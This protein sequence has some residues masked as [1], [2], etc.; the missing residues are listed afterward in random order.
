MNKILFVCHGT[1]EGSRELAVLVGQNGT[2]CGIGNSGDYGFT[3][4]E[5]S[6]LKRLIFIL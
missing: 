6:K 5:G 1:T 4:S 2:N 3:A